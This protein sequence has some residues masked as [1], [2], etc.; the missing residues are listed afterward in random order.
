MKKKLFLI[1]LIALL[2]LP[3]CKSSKNGNKKGDVVSD[4][5]LKANTK[6]VKKNIYSEFNFVERA[7]PVGYISSVTVSNGFYIV[8]DGYNLNFYSPLVDKIVASINNTSDTYQTYSSTV[9][10]G[11]VSLLTSA[12]TSVVDGLGNTLIYQSKRSYSSLSITSG[13]NAKD[14][15]YCDI[16]FDD[17]SIYFH[18]DATGKATVH[19][20]NTGDDY[21]SGGTIKGLDYVLLDD[22]GHPGYQRIK[23]SSRYI[24]FDN[25]GNEISSF[26]DPNADAS[27][28]VG[29]YL[30]YQNSVKLDDNNN[31]Y[32]FI[33]ETGERY[34][35]ETYRINY[36]TAK[37]EPI[38]VSYLLSTGIDDIHSFY[39]AKG[40]YTYAY[41]NLKTISDKK[42]LSNTLETYIIDA[43]GVL[44]DNV[45]GINL[46]AFQRLGSHYY[47]TSSKTI[48]D[49]NLNEISILTNMNPHKVDNAEFIVCEVEGKYGAVNQK[50][51]IVLPFQ[52]DAIFTNYISNNKVLA[53]ED[54][55]LALYSFDVKAASYSV[56]KSFGDS[57]VIN[58]FG[59]GVYK[60]NDDYL[61]LQ[62]G[63]VSSFK[64]EE[65]NTVSV[66][67][68]ISNV[69][70][71]ARIMTHETGTSSHFRV[72]NITIAR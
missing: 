13:I 42:I 8:D 2:A 68:M 34:S 22:F 15:Y 27:F 71:T 43:S 57:N 69:T 56:V 21:D 65:E 59:C 41:A 47:N 29:D 33:S 58:Y 48:Y 16:R 61:I 46:G 25:K 18:Y 54:G 12:G 52:F 63:E 19:S 37:K 44:H 60:I 51:Q 38:T 10:G 20:T 45:T 66:N 35:L 3:G 14:I 5:V 32:D 7:F 36:L 55:V 62:N 9:A 17:T 1:P 28:F 40:V 26:T 23:N 11:Y 64:V 24:V 30:I 6:E 67:Y 4:A 53:L 31:N 49:G 50:G 70:N 39:N 72:G